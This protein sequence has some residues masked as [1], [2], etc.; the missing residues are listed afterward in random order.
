VPKFI[1]IVV[2]LIFTFMNYQWMPFAIFTTYLLYGFMRP[3]LSRKMKQEIE[4]EVEE[5][6]EPLES[7]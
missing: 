3:F 4:E 7:P 1:L 2:V 6:E 5:D